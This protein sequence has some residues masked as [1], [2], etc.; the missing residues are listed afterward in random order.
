MLT[1]ARRKYYAAV[2]TIAFIV[3][4]LCINQKEHEND[5]LPLFSNSAFMFSLSVFSNDSIPIKKHT[6]QN[7]NI[8]F[9]IK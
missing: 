9:I 7:S 3:Y 8:I 1:D 4:N 6:F 5:I 2:K